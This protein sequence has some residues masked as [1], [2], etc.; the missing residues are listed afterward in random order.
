[1]LGLALVQQDEVEKAKAKAK[2]AEAEEEDLEEE[3]EVNIEQRVAGFTQAVAPVLLPMIE[4][5]GDLD[6]DPIPVI[7]GSGEAT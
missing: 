4:S 6:E 2:K 5:L 7:A 1:L 3:G